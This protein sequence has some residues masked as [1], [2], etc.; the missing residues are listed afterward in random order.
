[1]WMAL[2]A[3]AQYTAW[4][5]PAHQ[6]KHG[7][8]QAGISSRDNEE[9]GVCK[10]RSMYCALADLGRRSGLRAAGASAS[11]ALSGINHRSTDLKCFV[12]L[13]LALKVAR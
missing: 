2:H 4:L 10:D 6:Q 11:C 3:L 1:M 12:S 9:E 7:C 13:L 5:R 8:Q